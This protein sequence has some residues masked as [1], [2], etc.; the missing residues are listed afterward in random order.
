M[1]DARFKNQEAK[2]MMLDSFENFMQKK[3]PAVRVF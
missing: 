2:L 3:D 1:Q